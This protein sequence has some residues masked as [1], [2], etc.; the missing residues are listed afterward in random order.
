VPEYRTKATCLC[1]P[2]RIQPEVAFFY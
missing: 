1:A 2:D